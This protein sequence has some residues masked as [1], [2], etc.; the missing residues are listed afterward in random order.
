MRSNLVIPPNVEFTAEAQDDFD[1]LDGSVKI[2]VAKGIQKVSKNPLPFSEGGYGKPLGN[3]NGSDLSGYNKIKFSSI[4]VRCVY[5]CI[6]DETVGMKIIVISMRA[7]NE[8]YE[9]AVRRIEKYQS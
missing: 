9:E 6:Y 2:Q 1:R 7:D 8:V 3:K 4:G 5:Q